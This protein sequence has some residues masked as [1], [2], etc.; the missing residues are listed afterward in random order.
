MIS[1]LTCLVGKSCF[2][3][4]VLLRCLAKGQ[5]VIY[6]L[7]QRDPIH[8]HAD[9][10]AVIHDAA[11]NDQYREHPG[12][13]KWLLIEPGINE[14]P[15]RLGLLHD[16]LYRVAFIS[17]NNDKRMKR[18]ITVWNFSMWVMPVW[19]EREPVQLYV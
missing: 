10:V 3:I 1:V 8:F 17:P 18:L 9:V 6:A 11:C 12:M 4:Y 16:S 15:V 5:D 2:G 13:R 19:A 14:N 7:D